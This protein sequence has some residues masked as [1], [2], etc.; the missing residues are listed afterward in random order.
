MSL[1]HEK[2]KVSMKRVGLML[3]LMIVASSVLGCAFLKKKKGGDEEDPDP[4]V[5]VADA[6]TVVVS[7]TGA[8]NEANVLRYSNETALANEPATIGKDTPAR[9]FPGNGPEVAMLVKG[10]PVAKIA[11]YFSTGVLVMFD[12]PSGD[13]SKLIGWVSP[14]SFDVAAPAPT[15]V[16]VVPARDA[17][18]GPTP[19]LKDAGVTPAPVVDAGASKLVTPADAGGATPSFPKGVV[20]YAPINGKCGETHV[21][22]EGMCRKKCS[23]D[24]ECPRG[25]KCIAKGP[26]KVCTSG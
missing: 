21:V 18:R 6:S 9:N 13:G 4:S 26:A 23:T 22:S 7:G 16:V 11:Q 15:K 8:K 1:S 19:A 3:S 2:N 20:A 10:T 24:A 14:K 25:I 17:G 12:D 5:T